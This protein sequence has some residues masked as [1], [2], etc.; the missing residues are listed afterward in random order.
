M[1]GVLVVRLSITLPDDLAKNLDDYVREFGL[2]SRSKAVSDAVRAYLAERVLPEGE[3]FALLVYAYNPA[4]GETVR[5]LITTQH[6]YHDEIQASAHVHAREN[7]CVEVAFFEGVSKR[8]KKLVGEL[9]RIPGVITVRV[10]S[11]L[12]K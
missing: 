7:L 6:E 1:V 12:K 2:E 5:R 11:V 4:R 10:V 3:V 8:L 9:E